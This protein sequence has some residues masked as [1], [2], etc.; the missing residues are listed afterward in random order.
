SEKT[1][2]GNS[3]EDAIGTATFR[4][5][6]NGSLKIKDQR[7]TSKI[8][9]NIPCRSQYRMPRWNH[10]CQLITVSQIWLTVIVEENDLEAGHKIEIYS[11][12]SNIITPPLAQAGGFVG[13]GV[14][15]GPGEVG[16]AGTGERNM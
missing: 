6:R 4:V 15:E 7:S 3:S 1:Y 14:V 12:P 9:Q 11:R 8:I 2:S 5:L 10:R 16:G 13:T